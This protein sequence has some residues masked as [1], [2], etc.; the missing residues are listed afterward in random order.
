MKCPKC[1]SILPEDSHFCQFCGIKLENTI[2]VEESTYHD[3]ESERAHIGSGE[4][5]RETVDT[6][7][8]NARPLLLSIVLLAI[9][10]A[11]S[12]VLNMYQNHLSQE[13]STEIDAMRSEIDSLN[14][15]LEKIDEMRSEIES[16]NDQLE[17]KDVIVKNYNAL[18]SALDSGNLGYASENFRSNES[19]IVVDKN[20]KGRKF[21]LVANWPNGGSVSALEDSFFGS[22]RV[23]FDEDHWNTS[24]TMTVVP[25][26][27]G[28]TTVNFSNDVDSDTFKMIIIVTD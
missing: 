3:P 26:F 11:A 22:A 14:D 1:N 16:L 28:I 20:Q 17:K 4:R 9:F 18:I 15:Q 12:V 7:S 8:Y 27:E 13:K 24:T 6:P 2:V 5:R 10:F 21:T 23:Y 25:R 19:V